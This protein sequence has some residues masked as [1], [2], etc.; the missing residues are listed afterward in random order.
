MFAKLNKSFETPIYAVIAGLKTFTGTDI[1]G[2]KKG[3][4]YKKIWSPDSAKLYGVLPERY[5]KDFHLT[6]MTINAAIPPHTDTEIIT[7]INFYVYT[8]NCKTTFYNLKTDTPKKYQIENQTDGY[9]FDVGDLEE[10]SS[11]VAKPNET[12]VLD[13]KKVHGVEPLGEI[14]LRK[15]ITLGTRIHNYDAVCEMLRETGN[16]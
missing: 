5:H 16:L 7:T 10:V 8:D 15:A 11:F 4:D 2:V 12:W 9:I 13:V 14:K 6:V 1:D 3:I